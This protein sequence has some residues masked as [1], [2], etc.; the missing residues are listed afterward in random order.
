MLLL[1]HFRPPISR[2]V[3]WQELHGMWPGSIVRDLRKRLPAGY[4]CG[5]SVNPGQYLEV[6]VA[7]FEEFS[8]DSFVN[9]KPREYR[10]NGLIRQESPTLVLELEQDDF[11]EY[12]V[13]V[14]DATRD[15]H[16]VAAIELISPGNKDRAESRKAF[17]R[18]CLGLL[19]QGVAVSLVD[20]VTVRPQNLY[21]ELLEYF[22]G[23]DGTMGD[24]A[25]SLYAA[26]CRMVRVEE[27]SYLEAWSY[28]LEL[29]LALP[30]IPIW[31]SATERVPLDL[32]I[33]YAEACADLG[34]P[35]DAAIG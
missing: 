6:D 35:L 7:T 25:S 33:G 16:L 14:Y 30:T 17:L 24:V 15:R 21:A 8:I 11:A 10:P 13:R 2:R 27:K 3:S 32:G 19:A 1:D 5:P 4:H 22:G 9:V 26:S 18:K 12:E 20:V 28:R 23:R 29:G 34:I 31:L